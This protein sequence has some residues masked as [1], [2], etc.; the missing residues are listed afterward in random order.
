MSAVKSLALG[1]CVVALLSCRDTTAPDAGTLL[2]P[3]RTQR[4]I[5]TPLGTAPS[6]ALAINE[7]GQ[8]V[9]THNGFN[10]AFL[11]SSGTMT[12]LPK[13][14]GG[15]ET[16]AIGINNRGQ[17][18]GFSWT[19]GFSHA[20]LWDGGVITDLGTLPGAV[21]SRSIA[22][23]LNARGQV[24]G[25]SSS[26][27]DFGRDHAVLWENGRITD[28]GAPPGGGSQALGINDKGE[29][30]GWIQEFGSDTRAALWANRSWPP[31]GGRIQL[32]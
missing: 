14:P 18:V 19:S 12:D 23:A 15:Q 26:S 29:I 7:A 8:V 4:A 27:M 28:L 5:S 6:A 17:A 16:Q 3:A 9:G 30:V 31:P 21:Y 2:Q 25:S 32:C 1:S 13:L 20:V 11:W 24:V 10:S 22:H